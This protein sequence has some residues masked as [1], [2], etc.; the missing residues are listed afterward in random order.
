[1]S[2][3]LTFSVGVDVDSLWHYYRIHGLDESQASDHA[4][5]HG[6]PCFVELF[7]QLEIPA[8]FYC[9]AE[10]IERSPHCLK[11]LQTQCQRF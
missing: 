8:T 10:D 2:A 1:M 6:V 5:S 11:Q 9:V 4:W 7:N 3:N